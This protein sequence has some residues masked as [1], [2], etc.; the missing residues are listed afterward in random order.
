MSRIGRKLGPAG[1]DSF[2]SH[3]KMETTCFGLRQDLFNDLLA[4]RAVQRTGRIDEPLQ[5]WK[6]EGVLKCLFL[7]HYFRCHI[8][9][10][11][12][13]DYALL[14]HWRAKEAEVADALG[15][16]PLCTVCN[17]NVGVVCCHA[18]AVHTKPCT[19]I[20]QVKPSTQQ[21]GLCPGL[22]SEADR[23]VLHLVC[24]DH[25]ADGAWLWL[26]IQGLPACQ[27]IVME[28][29]SQHAYQKLQPK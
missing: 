10:R 22:L 18:A 12:V 20:D 5:V 9:Y 7:Q 2:V 21:K 26:P 11:Q 24:C 3:L 13:C 15:E 27:A 28:L 25:H 6:L 4:L 19:Q 23:D 17:K 8:E 14:S 16:S 29:E 1:I